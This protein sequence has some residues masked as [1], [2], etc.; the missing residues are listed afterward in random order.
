M[1]ELGLA[2]QAIRI[3]LENGV[4]EAIASRTAKK[5]DEDNIFALSSAS[6]IK[7]S[8]DLEKF[9]GQASEHFCPR[10]RLHIVDSLR[11][12]SD[13]RAKDCTWPK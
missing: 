11:L 7:L 8:C 5:S 3:E 13:H 1:V 10:S 9:L 2:D 6:V 12:S 4:V